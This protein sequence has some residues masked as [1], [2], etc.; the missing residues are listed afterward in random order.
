[1]NDHDFYIE[2]RKGILIIMG[3]MVR[4][5]GVGW[6]DFMPK[7]IIAPAPVYSATVSTP[8]PEYGGGAD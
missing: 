7:H 2:V 1:M 8:A 6:L 3:A 4:R 5:F